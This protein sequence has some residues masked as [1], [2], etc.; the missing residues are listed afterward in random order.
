VKYAYGKKK[1]SRLRSKDVKY[2][3]E[4]SPFTK[5]VTLVEVPYKGLFEE[6]Q[7]KL[8]VLLG[9]K[10]DYVTGILLPYSQN[11]VKIMI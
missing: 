1:T 8:R 3:V 9:L 2:Y 6:N 7:C 4:G 5:Y 10:R 11:L